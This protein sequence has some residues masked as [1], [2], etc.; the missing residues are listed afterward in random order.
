MVNKL[1][2]K[3]VQH[4]NDNSNRAKT[5]DIALELE[6][7]VN[8]QLEQEITKIKT[9]YY[10]ADGK[11]IQENADGSKFEYLPLP[12]GREEILAKIAD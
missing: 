10:S 12:D 2:D 5:A 7:D 9:I 11:L 4:S 8:Q 3:I 1:E 6:A